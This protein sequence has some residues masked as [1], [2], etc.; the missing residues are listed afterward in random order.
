MP[1]SVTTLVERVARVPGVVAVSLGGSRARGT[2][3]ARSDWDFGLYYRGAI[4]TE[5]IR[6]LGY[7]GQI[8]EPGEWGRIVNGGAWLEVET[9]RVDLLYRDLDMVEH[10]LSETEAGRFEI[11]AVA[12]HIAGLPTYTLAGELSLGTVLRG[13]LPR[14]S[15]PAALR[16]AAPPRWEGEAAFALRL[17]EG[18]GERGDAAAVA[19]LLAR[20]VMAAAHA[21]L[22][23]HGVWALNE[24]GLIARA[25]LD[26]A[27]EVLTAVGWTPRRLADSIARMRQLLRLTG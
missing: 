9:E 27:G 15:F 21:R 25:G 7:P 22:A 4:D 20:A 19:G 24:K 11:D 6:A 23:S 10:W 18:H 8:V 2:A 5:A 26:E 14:P 12:G 13:V 1:V 17:A 3:H 16:R